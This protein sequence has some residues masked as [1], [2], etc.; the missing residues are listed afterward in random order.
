MN[1][2]TYEQLPVNMKARAL[3]GKDGEFKIT[4]ELR[5]ML[6]YMDDGKLYVSK[7]HYA[8]PHVRGFQLKL[9]YIGRPF[10]VQTVD[11]S[12]IE[13]FYRNTETAQ[14]K[15]VQTDMQIAAKNLFRAAVE[16]R[17]S[18]IHIRVNERSISQIL[19]RIHNDLEVIEEHQ[20]GYVDQLV[21]TIYQSMADVSDPTFKPLERQDARIS[22]REKI[23]ANLDGIRIA[24]SPTV[25]GILMVLRLLYND[26]SKDTDLVRLGYQD[27][28]NIS[29]EYMKKRP[30][31]IIVIAGPTGSGKSTTLQ[32]ILTSIINETQGRK[33]IITVEDPPEYPIPGAVQT[34]VTN[35]STEQEVSAAYQKAIKA[36]MRL[37]P[38]IIMISEIRDNPTARLA[39]QAAMTGHQVWAT[40]H[41]N[42]ALAT[43]DRLLDLGVQMELLSDPTIIAGLVCQ[44]LVKLLCPQCKVPLTE[45]VENYSERDATRIMRCVDVQ[46]TYVQGQGCPHCNN[47]GTVGRTVVAETIVTD[48]TL[49]QF[50]RTHNKI[51][52]LEY[53]RNEQKGRS[54]LSHA[55]SKINAGLIDPFMAEDVVGSLDAF[56]IEGDYKVTNEDLSA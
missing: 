29:I 45:V 4:D 30:T 35:V 8:N 46:N 12:S 13:G 50:I 41:A 49:M 22:E 32:R 1:D 18:D 43:I 36:A 19:F 15:E 14:V 42:S 24:T 17:A 56:T 39:V 6:A 52:A 51:G 28:Q 21:S 53:W 20:K 25:E 44:R 5:G 38:D 11:F 33:H 3:T 7:T 27:Y 23:P 16:R 40:I 55:I 47:Y 2:L 31:G 9:K 10:T 48:N 34:P 37:D 54:M 26:A